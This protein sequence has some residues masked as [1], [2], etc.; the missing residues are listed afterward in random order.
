MEEIGTI[1]AYDSY[2]NTIWYV[3]MSPYGGSSIQEFDS[4]TNTTK[5]IIRLDGQCD[6]LNKVK[7][8][9]EGEDNVIFVHCKNFGYNSI[10]MIKWDAE[11]KEYLIVHEPIYLKFDYFDA[12]QIEKDTF[13]L[14]YFNSETKKLSVYIFRYEF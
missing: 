1:L 11:T 2:H 14:N 9:D 5:Q 4:N 8:S 3:L 6:F 7:N 13:V 12:Y 10:S